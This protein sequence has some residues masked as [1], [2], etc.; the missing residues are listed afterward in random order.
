MSKKFSR[1][2]LS[3]CV[4]ALV[5]SGCGQDAG[6]DKKQDGATSDVQRQ[7]ELTVVPE[8]D[9]Y[10]L[11][12]HD[13]F[14]GTK[15]DSTKWLDRSQPHRTESAEGSKAKYTMKDGILKLY[16]DE[17]TVD[18]FTGDKGGFRVCGIQTYAKNGL[19]IGDTVTP[20]EPFDGYTTKYG[21]FEMRCK[22]PSCGGGGHVAWWLIG[23]EKDADENGENSVQ[24]GE[25]DIV[26]TWYSTPN[27]HEPKVHPW[28][29]TNLEKWYGPGVSKVTLEGD[30]VNEWHT[31]AMNWTPDELIFYVDDKEVGRTEQSPQYE[32]CMLL[33]VYTNDDPS[34]WAGG[35]ESDVYPKEWEIDYIRVF[36][37]KNG[38]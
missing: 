4:G 6:N 8:K 10:V 16:I 1:L 21:Y 11:D 35:A 7:E 15:L 24:E 27:V 32:M 5:L 18:F 14:D 17:T 12:W 28:T 33:N 2:L 22:I 26:E 29:D 9:G 13:E 37:D 36:K 3:V 20:I 38:Y 34:Y 30:Y 23:A 25:I 31:Y 19:H